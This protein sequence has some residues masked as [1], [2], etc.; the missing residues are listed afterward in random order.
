MCLEAKNAP[1]EP[2]EAASSGVEK[3]KVEGKRS[4]K[5][6]A[7]RDAE[8]SVVAAPKAAAKTAAKT[9]AKAAKAD[10]AAE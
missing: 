10:K 1:D 9:A 3:E 6:P 8:A 5:P 7:S 4:R 2:E